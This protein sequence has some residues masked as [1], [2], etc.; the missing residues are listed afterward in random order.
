M[1]KSCLKEQSFTSAEVTKQYLEIEVIVSETVAD[2]VC[3]SLIKLGS[4][5]VWCKPAGENIAVIGYLSDDS[6]PKK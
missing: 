1:N 4:S 6:D 5:G 3:N 2:Q